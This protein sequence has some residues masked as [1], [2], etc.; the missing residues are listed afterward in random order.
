M[1]TSVGIDIG[2]HS[3]KLIEFAKEGNQIALMAAGSVPTPPKALTS[4]VQA[5][6]EAVSVA[7]KQ[8]VKDTG[9]KSHEVNIA[10]PESKVFTRVI[11]VPQLS[12][13][14]L[15][16]AIKWEAEQYIPLP[17]DQV[18]VDFTVLRESKD[19]GTNKMEVLLVAAPKAL[20]DKYLTILEMSGLTAIAAETEIIA[21]SRAIARSIPNV[22]TVMVVSLG[23]QTTD[24]AI[25]RSGILVFTRSV[26]AGGEAITRA[27]SQNLDFTMTQ[28]EEYK[29]TYGLQKDKL[30]G[31]IVNATKP[32]MDTIINEMKRAVAFYEEK[33]KD[34]HVETIMLSGGT[35]RLPGMVVYIAES[36]NVEVQMANP[37][38][39]IVRDK[40]FNVLS[41][42]G[43]N[44]CIAVGLALRQ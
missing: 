13:R 35:A 9:T 20:M 2:S 43:P 19:T 22:R 17:L 6:L 15:T 32:I 31:K 40:R 44:F 7:L 12:A 29:R 21:T 5:D 42:E 11:E 41:T 18:N 26:S 38:I 28:G 27:I 3:I 34:Q 1:N 8:L 25:L 39:G 4:S 36:I 14:E 37:W 10:L 33:Y 30:E 16:S 23:A 24:I